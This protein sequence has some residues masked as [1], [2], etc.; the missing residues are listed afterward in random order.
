MSQTDII[1]L[2]LSLLFGNVFTTSIILQWRLSR[3][4]ELLKEKS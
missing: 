2:L 4:I 3:I 1:I